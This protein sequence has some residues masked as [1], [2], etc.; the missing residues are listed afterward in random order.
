LQVP[1]TVPFASTAVPAELREKLAA[2]TAAAE[3]K[4]AKTARTRLFLLAIAAV[5][6]SFGVG[7]L[8]T[9]L[10]LAR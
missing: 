10:V 8:L 6:A 9:H 5:A 7:L 2:V 1:A 4:M 3:R